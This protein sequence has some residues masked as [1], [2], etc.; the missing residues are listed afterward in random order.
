MKKYLFIINRNKRISFCKKTT[1]NKEEIKKKKEEKRRKKK[2]KEEKRRKKKKNDMKKSVYN[3][4]KQKNFKTY[5][6]Q[7]KWE[8]IDHALLCF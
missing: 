1:R 5:S 7:L 6:L 8:Q 3:K 4:S 2:K